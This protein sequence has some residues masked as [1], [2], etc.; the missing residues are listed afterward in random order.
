[1]ILKTLLENVTMIIK[2][3]GIRHP[4]MAQ[5]AVCMGANLI[6]IVFHPLSPR[7]VRPDQAKAIS[8]ATRNAG[9]LPVA[10]FV[11]HTAFEMNHICKEAEINMVQLHGERARASHHLLP[12]DYPRIY[13]KHLSDKGELHNN[14]G[15]QYLDPDRDFILIDHEKP[16][17]GNMINRDQFKYHLAFRWIL[18]GGLTPA[19]V[20]FAM[21]ELNPDGVDV[22]SGVESLRG[23]KDGLLIQEFIKSVRGHHDIT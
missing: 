17:Q 21:S 12:D 13:A 8:I 19:N 11:N 5:H 15:L 6:G 23:E 3:C 2:I 1:M 7:Y 18:A 22:S 14:I 10:I 16:G 4:E 20:T 9:A